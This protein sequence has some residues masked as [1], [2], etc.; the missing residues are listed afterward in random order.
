MRCVTHV[1]RRRASRTYCTGGVFVLS[2]VLTR[3]TAMRTDRYA[4]EKLFSPLHIK[5]VMW[6]YSPLGV[7]QT[8]GGL[9]LSSRDLL[10]IA[11]LYLNGGRWNGRQIVSS[12]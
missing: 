7:P 10:K 11:Q 2:E 12:E 4:Q 1:R 8:G 6:V 9:R 3:A 5:N